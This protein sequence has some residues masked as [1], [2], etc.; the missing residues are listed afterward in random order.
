MGSCARCLLPEGKFDISL[1]GQ[2]ICN[3]CNFWDMH[4]QK[5]R[6]GNRLISLF[7]GRLD[8]VRG[9]YPYDALVGVAEAAA[10]FLGGILVGS[11]GF[12]VVF[13]IVSVIFLLSTTFMLKL[14]EN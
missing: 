9:K 3:R 5:F 1:D 12:E 13:Y 14:R 11:F 8:A 10:I 6:D 2:G 7:R 4:K